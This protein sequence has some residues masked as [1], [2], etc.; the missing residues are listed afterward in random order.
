MM[1]SQANVSNNVMI[2]II[3]GM[4]ITAAHKT[5]NSIIKIRFAYKM[6]QNDSLQI[7]D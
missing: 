1:V 4:V 2:H 5:L 3:Y 6:I 7:N